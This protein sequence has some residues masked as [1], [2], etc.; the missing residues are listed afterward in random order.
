VCF[1]IIGIASTTKVY[2]VKVADAKPK[3]NRAHFDFSVTGIARSLACLARIARDVYQP[4]AAFVQGVHDCGFAN[5][6][7]GRPNSQL[8][9][10]VWAKKR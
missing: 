5:A 9:Q 7:P 8:L 2:A 4:R 3:G 10:Q 6:V 1:Y